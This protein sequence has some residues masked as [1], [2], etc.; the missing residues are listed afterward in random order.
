MPSYFRTSDREAVDAAE[1]LE[2]GA[3]RSGYGYRG[4]GLMFKDAAGRAAEPVGLALYDDAPAGYAR[5]G[6]TLISISQAAFEDRL[7]N[8]WRG[9]SPAGPRPQ[10]PAFR[11]Y[12]HAPVSDSQAG[13]QQR[14]VDAWKQPAVPVL[15]AEEPP[16]E[17]PLT[18][19]GAESGRQRAASQAAYEARV[20]A[21]W[22]TRA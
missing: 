17:Q 12:R 15:A 22:K 19:A 16:T 7:A 6:S 14:L 4:D 3:L 8:S 1:A 5:R 20:A 21:A 11:P 9:G 18:D 10:P 13:Y 2:N